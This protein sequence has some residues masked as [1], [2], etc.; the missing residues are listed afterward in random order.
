M[1]VY[2]QAPDDEVVLKIVAAGEILYYDGYCATIV[3]DGFNYFLKQNQLTG[4][5]NEYA[6]YEEG[7]GVKNYY[8]IENDSHGLPAGAELSYEYGTFIST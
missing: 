1:N 7:I 4:N 2:C 5:D 6:E 8:T 3:A